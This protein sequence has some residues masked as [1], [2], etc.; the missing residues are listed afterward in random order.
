MQFGEALV[1]ST[2]K[3]LRVIWLTF[4]CTACVH[5]QQDVFVNVESQLRAQ[6]N[7]AALAS[8]EKLN[9]FYDNRAL[10]ELNRGMILHYMGSYQESISAFERAKKY[11]GILDPVS[12]TESIA[13]YTLSEQLRAYKAT[14][15]EK[16]FLHIYQIM[17]YLAINQP[18]SARVELMQVDLALK[19]LNQ[20]GHYLASA[21]ARY[22]SGL[23]FE[24]LNEQDN[25]LIA[26]RQAYKNYRQTDEIIPRDLKYR[27]VNLTQVAGLYNETIQWQKEFNLPKRHVNNGN[28]QLV[29]F[30]NVDFAPVKEQVSESVID[31]SSGQWY[32]L[33]LPFYQSRNVKNIYFEATI[34]NEGTLLSDT[35][36]NIESIAIDNLQKQLPELT[37][38][39]LSRNI[40]R[41]AATKE[42]EEENE[43]LGGLVNV[44]GAIFDEAD[45]RNWRTLP[46]NI[47][48]SSRYLLPGNYSI[49]LKVFDERGVQFDHHTIDNVVIEP[50]RTKFLSFSWFKPDS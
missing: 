36:A 43:L 16:L 30:Y 37:L 24:S 25:A 14:V 19:T 9:R 33:S 46:N 38:R 22:V 13:A 42:A 34:N 17:N 32:R 47:Q 44:L 18:N 35:L 3:R 7:E 12:I 27:L 21:A 41:R 40:A 39:A 28:S 5:M 31:P 6:Q 10:Y 15:Y 2:L 1:V 4:L 45:I 23:I 48:I 29:I 8:L 11:I 20:E 49:S 50:N 26:Y